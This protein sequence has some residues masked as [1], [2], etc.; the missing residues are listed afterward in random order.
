M[1]F[2][3]IFVCGNISVTAFYLDF[4]IILI[5][6]KFSHISL[7]IFVPN[8]PPGSLNVKRVGKQPTTVTLHAISKISLI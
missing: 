7:M 4:N 1:L 3:M 6:L 2:D 8:L 5:F